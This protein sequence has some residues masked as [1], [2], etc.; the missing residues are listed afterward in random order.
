MG[1]SEKYLNF[2][3]FGIENKEKSIIASV[4]VIKN[5]ILHSTLEK[6]INE[7]IGRL[8]EEM[9]VH[10][11]STQGMKRDK[12][13]INTHKSEILPQKDMGELLNTIS[14]LIL[15]ILFLRE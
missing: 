3:F 14:L 13:H 2:S 7:F 8:P 15:Y 10:I 12:K 9:I 1:M 11:E 4:I 5:Q 6:L